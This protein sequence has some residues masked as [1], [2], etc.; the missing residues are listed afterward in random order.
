MMAE[1]TTAAVGAQ[2][3]GVAVIGCGRIGARRASVT[4]DHPR[5]R[6]AAV[7]DVDVTCARDVAAGDA[8]VLSEW[9]EV[10][11]RDDVDVIVVATP[12]AFLA[13]VAIAAL[14]SGRHVLMEKPMGRDL[15]EAR[16]V[17]DAAALSERV[18]RIGFNHRHHPAIRRAAELVRGGAIGRIVTLRARYGHGGRP[19]LEREWRSDPALAGGGE[20]LDQ[21]I[22]VA[23]LF[24]WFAGMPDE[25]FAFVQTAVWQIA[26]LE[27]NAYG[28][29]RFRE[30]AVGQ[31]HASMTQWKNLFSLE[32][33][34]ET[35]AVVVE[36]LG[37]SYGTERLL[38]MERAFEGGPPGV[39]EESFT[40]DDVSW[41]REWDAFL[42][43]IDGNGN[44]EAGPEDGVAAM[45]IIEALYRSAQSG[46]QVRV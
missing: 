32:V 12:N 13:E 11:E 39:R 18:L 1:G 8:Q 7:A 34:G 35:G 19:G 16:R 5:T 2:Q 42:D 33:H 37:G 23:D 9:R 26:P 15:K 27:D 3:L 10:F 41:S 43:A 24:H 44:E 6:L 38:I 36:G 29:L 17:A 28:L 40:G 45:R 4:R 14:E 20:L 30:G 31:L 22:H 25:A 46:K 21:G